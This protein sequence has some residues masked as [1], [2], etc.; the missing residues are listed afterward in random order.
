[1][2]E[3]TEHA[4]PFSA[5]DHVQLAMPFEQEDVARSFYVSVLG[6]TEVTKPEELAKRGGVWFASGTVQIH[7]GIEADFRPA[8]RAHPALRCA[9]Y[10]SLVDKIRTAGF[11][12]HSELRTLPD[13]SRHAYVHDPFGNRI[14]LVAAAAAGLAGWTAPP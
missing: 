7:L 9:D 3:Q 2:T 4:E 11:D 13:G 12:V 6:M 8:R 1:M 14:E 10:D 5:F